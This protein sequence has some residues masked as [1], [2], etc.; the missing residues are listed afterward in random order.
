MPF[1]KGEEAEREGDN[2]K[3]IQSVTLTNDVSRICRQTSTLQ[4]IRMQA[5]KP[6]LLEGVS[7]TVPNGDAVGGERGSREVQK[8][9]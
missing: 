3:H 2:Q 5:R 8:R 4:L 6:Y 9:G 7:E 1:S